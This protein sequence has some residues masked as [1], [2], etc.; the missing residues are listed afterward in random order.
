M[1]PTNCETSGE[2]ARWAG[3][4]CE[5]SARLRGGPAN[6]ASRVGDWEAALKEGH[7]PWIPHISRDI[8]QCWPIGEATGALETW[9]RPNLAAAGDRHHRAC[10]EALPPT[11]VNP[12]HP[13][14]NVVR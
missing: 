3:R 7:R 6:A 14:E 10:P 8:P 11:N 12:C 2:T 4:C 1:R 13:R 5:T 9:D